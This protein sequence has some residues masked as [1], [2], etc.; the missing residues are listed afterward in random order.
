MSY[1]SFNLGFR[2]FVGQ[3]KRSLDLLLGFMIFDAVCFLGKIFCCCCSHCGSRCWVS[4]MLLVVGLL[5]CVFG[6]ALSLGY[7]VLC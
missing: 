5:G 7:G 2:S 1:R 6:G 3:L 4:W